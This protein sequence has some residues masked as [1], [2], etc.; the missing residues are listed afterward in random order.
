MN[1]NVTGSESQYSSPLVRFGYIEAG[2]PFAAAR[3]AVKQD[4]GHKIYTV[5]WTNSLRRRG[6]RVYQLDGRRLRCIERDDP[7]S[8]RDW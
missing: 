2:N 7:Y 5:S 4:G 1:Y 8:T 6:E 3:A